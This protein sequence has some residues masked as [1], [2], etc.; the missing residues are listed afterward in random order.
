MSFP[1]TDGP[2]QDHRLGGVEPPQG[3]EVTQHRGGQLRVGGKVEAFEGGLFLELRST[4][5]PGQCGRF[6]PGDFIFAEHL[7]EFEVPEG[8]VAGLGETSIKGVEHASQLQGA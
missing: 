1:D 8:A 5:P 6:A 7:Q 4:D 2:E 3:T